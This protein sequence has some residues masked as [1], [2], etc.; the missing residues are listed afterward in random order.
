MLRMY[1]ERLLRVNEC[2]LN[3]G[4]N[5]TFNIHR[6]SLLGHNCVCPG[7]HHSEEA[8]TVF[9]LRVR[10][11]VGRWSQPLEAMTRQTA[12]C[13]DRK[14]MGLRSPQEDLTGQGRGYGS[15]RWLPREGDWVRAELG[16]EWRPHLPLALISTSTGHCMPAGPRC[17]LRCVVMLTGVW[18]PHLTTARW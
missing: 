10:G 11:G 14:P 12:Q 9:R 3:E 1:L 18:K 6:A 2:L 8:G 17:S 5:S 4:I 7:T 13:C 15:Q 16:S